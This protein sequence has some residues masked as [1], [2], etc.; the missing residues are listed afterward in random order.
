MNPLQNHEF[1]YNE[2]TSFIIFPNKF[3]LITI[4]KKFMCYMKELQKSFITLL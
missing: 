1:W 3:N 4:Y 2:L